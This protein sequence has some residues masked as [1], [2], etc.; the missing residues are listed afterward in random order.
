[1]RRGSVSEY[2]ALPGALAIEAGKHGSLYAATLFTGPG[3]VVRIDT[4]TGGH[5]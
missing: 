3:S 2:V 4:R 5:R 1:V